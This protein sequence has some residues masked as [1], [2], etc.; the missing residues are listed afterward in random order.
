M[1]TDKAAAEYINNFL[2]FVV[3]PNEDRGEMTY[4]YC[5]GVNAS[6]F[7]PLTE[8]RH[9]I[10]S[11]PSVRGLQLVNHE[12]KALALERGATLGA[13]KT[14]DCSGIVMPTEDIWVTDRMLIENAPSSFPSEV[15][16][17]CVIN[18]IRKIIKAGMI[19]AK[20]PDTLLA[21][22]DLQ[23]YIDSLCIQYG[24]K[25]DMNSPMLK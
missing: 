3:R 21:P 9:G 11:N 22:A 5:S 12:V 6:R 13:L 2:Y 17:Y 14:G 24:K 15:I 18:L 20:A 19:D 1:L 16:N 10:G 7:R 4:V 23:A 8:G 25:R